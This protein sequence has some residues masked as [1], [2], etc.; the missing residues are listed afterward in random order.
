VKWTEDGRTRFRH[1]LP[2]SA[3]AEDL[4]ARIAA[5][6]A[7]GRP[8]EA[9][10][11]ERLSLIGAD[12][13]TRRAGTHPRSIRDDR[14][15]WNRHVEPFFGAMR[16][17]DVDAA[18][19]R[20]FVEVKLAEK[21]APGTVKLC[22]ALLSTFFSDLVERKLAR[23]NPVK[24]LPRATRRLVRPKLDP[25]KT[26][27]VERL[28][29][30]RRI[31]QAMPASIRMA[32]ALGALAGLRIGEIIGLH[33][34]DVDLAG[35]RLQLQRQVQ[36]GRATGLKDDEGRTVPIQDALLVLLREHKLATGG[37]GQLFVP[38]HPTR[39]GRPEL[40]RPATFIRPHTLNRQLATA[41][42]D[43]EIKVQLTWYHATRHTFAS[44][45][46]LAG[47]SMDKLATI[48]GHSSSE[49]TRRYAHLRPDLFPE[50][51]YQV[52]QVDMKAKGGK[53]VKLGRGPKAP[54]GTRSSKRSSKPAMEPGDKG[55][56]YAK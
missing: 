33:W 6:I 3:D 36:H 38:Q 30:V 32:Y 8:G 37:A 31:Y 29:D 13:I 21:L 19:I 43:C 52:I 39:G 53:M 12:W 18:S 2:T 34:E 23:A 20:R 47:G 16:P 40:D 25:R 35:R 15:R 11:E 7:A 48:L 1:G 56:K 5:E 49:V 22:T 10:T 26:P 55:S 54:A 41:L 28:E 51:D 17:D 9:G 42:K 24:G 46:V 27:F 50:A 44:H 4:R 45:W 14:S